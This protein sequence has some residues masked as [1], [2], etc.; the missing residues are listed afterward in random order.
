[1]TVCIADPVIGLKNGIGLANDGK[2]VGVGSIVLAGICKIVH[3]LGERQTLLAAVDGQY[4]A[5]HVGVVDTDF[6]APVPS[7]DDGCLKVG[8]DAFVLRL[9]GVDEGL[10]ETA[11]GG[12]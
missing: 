12:E 2:R 6:P 5:V 4:R 9:G 10:A 3:C 7:V 11:T 1:M 8:L